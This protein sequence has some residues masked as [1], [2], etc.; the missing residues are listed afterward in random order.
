MKKSKQ[1]FDE[2]Y[3]ELSD[4]FGIKDIRKKPQTLDE[5]EGMLDRFGREFERRVI[6]KTTQE[7]RESVD[8]KKAVKDVVRGSKTSGSGK[9]K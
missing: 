5:I 9:R 7:Q 4:E 3:K 1:I 6:E 8:K 2:V